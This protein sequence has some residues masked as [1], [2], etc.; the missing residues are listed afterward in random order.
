MKAT[1]PLQVRL[2]SSDA[3]VTQADHC[4]YLIQQPRL[5]RISVGK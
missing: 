4:A 3:V 1:D 5:G 2:L